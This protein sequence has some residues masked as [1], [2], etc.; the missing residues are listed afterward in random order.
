MS[1]ILRE[2]CPER[3]RKIPKRSLPIWITRLAA[4]VDPN[5]RAVRPD[6][7]VHP[8]AQCAYVT[9][10]TGV[11]FRPVKESVSDA[12]RSLIALGAA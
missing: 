9:D 2:A 12:G 1:V 10:L 8:H 3:A 4:F 7:G 5:I 11:S 6:L